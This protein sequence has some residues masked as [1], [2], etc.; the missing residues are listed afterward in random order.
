MGYLYENP[1][2]QIPAYTLPQISLR[3]QLAYNS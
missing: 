3:E 1:M 2:K